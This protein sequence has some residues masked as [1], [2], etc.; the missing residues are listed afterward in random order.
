[1]GIAAELI[2]IIDPVSGRLITVQLSQY[3][4]EKIKTM[5][6]SASDFR[7]HWN[8]LQE[9]KLIIEQLENMSISIE[10]LMEVTSQKDADPFDLL[11]FV[12]YDLM[13]KTRRQRAEL[14]KTNKPDFF[15]LY[16]E[17]ARRIL[18]MILDKYIDFGL[19]QI[20]PD[21]ISVEPFTQQGNTIE[22]VN[23]FGGFEKYKK[24]IE[25][26][27]TLLYSEAA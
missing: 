22:I 8:N 5:F 11:C 17:K 13:P 6:P 15:L 7:S 10:Q 12:A 21:I 24:A 2:Q 1:M 14:L 23:E 27:Q 25:E 26:L 16:S 19:G 4:K 18:Q 9:R 3:A 20:R